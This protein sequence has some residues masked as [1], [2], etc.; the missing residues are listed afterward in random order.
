LE[1]PRKPERKAERAAG[2]DYPRKSKDENTTGTTDT[3][4]GSNLVNVLETLM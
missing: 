1:F 4:V 3:D 2:G